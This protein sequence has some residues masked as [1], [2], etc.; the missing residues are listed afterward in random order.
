MKLKTVAAAIAFGAASI[1]TWAQQPPVK[2]AAVYAITGPVAP[3]GVP[4]QKAVQ[5]RAEQINERGGWKGRKVEVIF[6]DTEGNGNK[7][8]QL[9]RKAIETDKVDLILGP[10]TTGEA[11]AVAPI[12]NSSQVPMITHSGAQSVV[13]PATPY[14]FQTAQYD[15]VGVPVVLKEFQKKGFKKIAL[16][17][18]TDGFGQSGLTLFKEMTPKYGMTLVNEQFDR[19]D[20]DMT[21]QV[22]RAKQSN[23]DVLLVW[24]TFPAP[25]IILRN[26]KA[27]GYG[28]PIY[29][30]F[31]MAS[32]E[33]LKQSG[34]ASEN[35]FVMTAAM[36][37]PAALPDS[38]PNKSVIMKDYNTFQARFKEAPNP[39]AQHAMDAM[40]IVD[41]AVAR[42]G[43]TIDRHSL[44]DAIEKTDLH[45]DNGYFKFSATAH[46]VS[47]QDPPIVFLKVVNNA[48]TVQ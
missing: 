35:T 1:A 44:R 7:A 3:Y 25:A 19:Q 17:S 33:F 23:A 28:K 43:G 40:A 39:S 5:M 8:V 30:S 13:D 4:Q 31:A 24:S 15:R 2:I 45:G 26:A 14:V 41:A 29:N 27:M 34:P 48:F 10:S 46:G 9:V 37:M 22:L 16:L 38:H 11:L 20:T 32:Q 47:D 36:L 6:Y 18:S 42:I 12:A 21:A